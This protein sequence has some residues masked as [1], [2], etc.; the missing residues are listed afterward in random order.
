MK[1]FQKRSFFSFMI[2]LGV[3]AN[4]FCGAVLT[5]RAEVIDYQALAEANLS[6][7][8]ESNEIKNWP[9]GPILN[10]R[11]A[12][13][14]DADSGAILYAKN[15]HE[16]L[17][18]ASTTKILTAYIAR[19]NSELN[20][21]IEYS[22]T[23]V[24]SID[25][26]SDSNIGIKAGEAITME[27]SLYGLL[28][29]SGSECGNAIGEHISGSMEAFVDLMN[30]TAKELGCTDSHFV[31]TNG[32][33][34]DNHYTSTHDLALIGQKFFSDDV[35]CRMS[36]TVSYKIPASATLSQDLIPNSK[37]KLLPGKTYA[38]EYLVGSK[39]G[40]TANARS[41]L[42]SCAQ[43]DGL[44][45]ICVVMM[46][47]S[48]QQFKDTTYQVK[49]GDL[50]ANTFNQSD[51]L[52]IDPDAKV[53]L[54]DTLT[55]ADL[56]SELSYDNLKDGQAAVIHYSYEG[57]DLG[58]APILFSSITPFDFSAEPVSETESAAITTAD[59]SSKADANSV[60]SSASN[61]Q[62]STDSSGTDGNVNASSANGSSGTQGATSAQAG[63]AAS[64]SVASTT[65]P[66][67]VS[68]PGGNVIFLNV[69]KILLAVSIV[70]V[71]LIV[72]LVIRSILIGH[73]RNRKRRDIMKRH[74]SRKDEIIDFDRYTDPFA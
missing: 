56:D 59:G 65:S 48:P 52:S 43:K 74:R 73:S 66:T 11:S 14:M 23:A 8:V 10:A 71:I 24:H 29:G 33:H 53:L 47:E 60:Q 42:V 50:F 30:Q 20:E 67:A 64:E 18:P 37:N 13:L 62:S 17:Y 63:T 3:G 36:D 38:Y 19:Q 32:K 26:R 25:W 58:S 4:L 55:F 35:L 12:I 22:D 49:N 57:Q 28:V 44:K 54:P 68:T 41:N 72:I 40:Y 45:L 61:A 1:F 31:N 7:P 51:I 9:E 15:I 34:D 46:E 5:A 6:I 70:A 69:R 27:Q 2:A 39:T 16:K 21:M